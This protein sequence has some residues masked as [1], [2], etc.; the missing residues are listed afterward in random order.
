VQTP[1]ILEW[2][3]ENIQKN[4]L[5]YHVTPSLTHL[6]AM[7]EQEVMCIKVDPCVE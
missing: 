2:I 4:N 3:L 5:I 1:Q 7:Q 6:I